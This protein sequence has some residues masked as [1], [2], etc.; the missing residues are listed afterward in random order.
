MIDHVLIDSMA[1][2]LAAARK[3]PGVRVIGVDMEADGFHRYPERT[4]LIQLIAPGELPWLIDPLA[5]PDLSALGSVLAD[6]AVRVIFHAS[7]FDVR[8]L[9]R[10]FG[11]QIRGL[12]DTAVAGQ[13]AG[14]RL[15]GLGNVIEE[16]LGVD[17]AKTKRLQRFDWSMRPLPADAM[18]Y[19]AGDVAYL[20]ELDAA[21]E[22]RLE[23]LGRLSWLEE[24]CWRLEDVRFDP[25]LSLELASLKLKGASDLSDR[26]RAIL[27]SIFAFREAEAMRAG[28]PPHFV[29]SNN[30]LL[31]LARDPKLDPGSLPGAGRR[32]QGS[33]LRQLRDAIAAGQLSDPIPW[34]RAR[35]RNLWTPAARERLARLKRWRSAEAAALDIEA[36]FVWS[37]SHLDQI[38]LR[39]GEAR[40]NPRALDEGDPSWVR[41]W[42]WKELGPSLAEVVEQL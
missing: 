3:L 2:W 39:P 36:G 34:P 19:A 12:R 18:A 29:L 26:E 20:F 42:Q 9:Y 24:E 21:L 31:A 28:R 8:A 13:L 23:A 30:A 25:P 35:G 11:F 5:I 14:L 15:L 10:D 32:I 33:A 40:E 22:G 17:L 1:N 27:A 41:E 38:A 7:G 6:P 37:A 4:S 16:V